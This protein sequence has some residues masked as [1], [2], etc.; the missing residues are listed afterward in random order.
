MILTVDVGA[1]IWGTPAPKGSLRCVSR[2]VR[3]WHPNLQEDNAATK[4]WRDAVCR[5]A[6]RI[7]AQTGVT[8]IEGPIGVDIT[9]T[10][11]LPASVRPAK[12]T[13]P[14]V[15]GKGA[16]DVD[17]LA[18]TILDALQDAGMYADDAQVVQLAVTKCYPHTPNVPDQ[19]ER[20]GAT[21]RIY[22]IGA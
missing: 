9:V 5:A 18:R 7:T 21:I 17:K 14:Y 10:L 12:R 13:W 1:H 20:P 3:G 6:R 15:K 19:L 8:G 16:G 22:P 2:H 4:P 11:P